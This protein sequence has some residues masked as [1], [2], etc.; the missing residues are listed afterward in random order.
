M[1]IETVI[2]IDPLRASPHEPATR[3][4]LATPRSNNQHACVLAKPGPSRGILSAASGQIGVDCL[5]APE[6]SAAG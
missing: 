5:S 1:E 2:V 3:G 4:T 6:R